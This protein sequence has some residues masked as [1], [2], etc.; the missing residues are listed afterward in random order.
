M[1]AFQTKD[2]HVCKNGGVQLLAHSVR[3]RLFKITSVQHE[4]KEP[5]LKWTDQKGF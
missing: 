2:T 3:I 1:R 5:K 4:E